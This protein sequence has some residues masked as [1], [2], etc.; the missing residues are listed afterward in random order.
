ME[1]W[2]IKN[3]KEG[4][5]NKSTHGPDCRL[6]DAGKS[7]IPNTTPRA[8]AYTHQFL[9]NDRH[10]RRIGDA[11]QQIQGLAAQ[12]LVRVLQAVD[13]HQLVIGRRRRVDADLWAHGTQE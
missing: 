13:D 9:D 3:E 11:I 5:P 4:A 1:W 12:R 2:S 7:K 10:I 6:D 8:H